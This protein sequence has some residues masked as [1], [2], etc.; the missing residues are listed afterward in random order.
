MNRF[1][2]VSRHIA[3][4]FVGIVVTAIV[5]AVLSPLG[6][7]AC[8][9]CIGGYHW[10]FYG[11]MGFGTTALGLGLLI[12]FWFI[13]EATKNV[14]QEAVWAWHRRQYRLHKTPMPKLPGQK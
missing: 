12:I 1:R 11:F 14:T 10:A 2:K 5:L 6:R 13:G 7:W 3:T 8:W 4:I 9:D